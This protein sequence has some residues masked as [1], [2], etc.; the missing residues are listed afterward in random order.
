MLIETMTKQNS[1]PPSC[2]TLPCWSDSTCFSWYKKIPLD[3]FSTTKN[4][5]CDEEWNKTHFFSSPNQPARVSSCRC[6]LFYKAKQRVATDTTINKPGEESRNR[7]A[8]LDIF[9]FDI[10]SFLSFFSHYTCLSRHFSFQFVVG[11]TKAPWRAVKG[12]RGQTNHGILL[13]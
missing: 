5:S 9:R 11:K 13:L 4:N 12:S 3:S 2:S 1:T 7:R 8:F 6:M 10:P